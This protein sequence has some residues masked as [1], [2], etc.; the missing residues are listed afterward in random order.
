[1]DQSELLLDQPGLPGMCQ[2][3]DA[4][5]DLYQG[6]GIDERGAIFTRPEVVGFILDLVGYTPS[7][8]LYRKSI[9]EPSFGSGEFL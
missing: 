2:L 6:A 4:A 1:M 7:S 3:T 9:L 5:R 8:A